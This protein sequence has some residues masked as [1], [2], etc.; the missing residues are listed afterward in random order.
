[1][2]RGENNKSV[3]FERV[4]VYQSCFPRQGKIGELK[5][6]QSKVPV[7]ELSNRINDSVSVPRECVIKKRYIATFAIGC[8][9]RKGFGG[10]S[11]CQPCK[12]WLV[13]LRSRSSLRRSTGFILSYKVRDLLYHSGAGFSSLFLMAEP[14]DQVIKL[15]PLPGRLPHY[16]VQNFLHY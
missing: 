8:R 16:L 10:Y 13:F 14:F 5:S 7:S 4:I 1:M 12:L 6:L 2:L 15:L 9:R 11:G 3:L